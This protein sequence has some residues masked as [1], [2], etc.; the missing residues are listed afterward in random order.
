MSELQ[1]LL[2]LMAENNHTTVHAMYTRDFPAADFVQFGH[3][4]F[5]YA[6]PVPPNVS[7]TDGVIEHFA[8]LGQQHMLD[9]D[10]QILVP[11]RILAFWGHCYCSLP[12][13]QNEENDNESNQ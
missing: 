4:V 6:E 10:L 2:I 3:L 11:P 5:V 7:L 9:V 1:L 13:I 8:E 12:L